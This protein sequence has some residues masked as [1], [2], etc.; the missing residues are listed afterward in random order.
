MVAK[1]RVYNEVQLAFKKVPLHS[2]KKRKHL[3]EAKEIQA[4]PKCQVIVI[5]LLFESHF[6]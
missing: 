6:P 3:H 1:Q 2:R 5:A 4:Q